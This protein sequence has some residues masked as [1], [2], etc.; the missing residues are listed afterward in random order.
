MSQFSKSYAFQ[1]DLTHLGHFYRQYQRLMAHWKSVLDLPIL[2]V[3]YEHLV[4]DSE[5]QSR[6]MVEFLGLPW[7]DRCL[8]FHKTK[9][10]C[11]TASVA[12]IRRPIYDKSVRRWKKYEKHLAPLKAALQEI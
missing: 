6:R 1:R 10:P 4:A 11:M 7:D 9:R 2:D 12:Q 8:Q 3:Q 5:S